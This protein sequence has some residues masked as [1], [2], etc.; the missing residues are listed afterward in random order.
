MPAVKL[1]RCSG[2]KKA[3]YC[4]RECQ[5]EAWPLHIFD[6]QPGQHINTAYHLYKACRADEFPEDEETRRDYGLAKAARTMGESSESKLFGLYQGL[7]LV[8]KVPPKVVHKWRCKGRLVQGIKDTFEPIPPKD[9]G[10]YYPWFLE[11]QSV[12]DSDAPDDELIVNHVSEVIRSAWVFTGGPSSDSL[13]VIDT[14]IHSLPP[15]RQACHA[16]CRGFVN[17][18]YPNPVEELWID[19]GFVAALNDMEEQDLG[20]AYRALIKVCTF[21]ELCVA[22]ESS[23]IPTLFERY[24]LQCTR[25]FRDVMARSPYVRKSVWD[26]K[27]RMDKLKE[28]GPAAQ[29]APARSVAVDYGYRNCRKHEDTRKLDNV[30]KSFFA[31]PRADPMALHDACIQGKLL[32]YLAPFMRWNASQKKAYD[33]LLKTEYPLLQPVDFAGTPALS[34][35]ICASSVKCSISLLRYDI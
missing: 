32:Q 8:M 14:K 29:D 31:H 4:S 25:H 16:L 20:T 24:G 5:T 33:R 18:G 26:L 3:I 30:Y 10:A 13:N 2:C 21:E 1:S 11:N 7:L 22:Y 27:H 19:F 17:G 15:P 34:A 35:P 12:L 23:S 6:C 28:G 9:R